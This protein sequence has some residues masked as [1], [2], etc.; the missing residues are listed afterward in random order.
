MKQG[1]MFPFTFIECAKTDSVRVNRLRWRAVYKYPAMLTKMMS[2][3]H[4]V[5]PIA[6]QFFDALIIKMLDMLAAFTNV[7]HCLDAHLQV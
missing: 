6:S 5:K 3:F 1:Q 2:A 7:G 4:F